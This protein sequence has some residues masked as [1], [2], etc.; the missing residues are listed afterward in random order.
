MIRR[1]P[2]STRTD[3][4]FPYTTLFRSH[5][6][7]GLSTHA[8]GDVAGKLLSDGI[9]ADGIGYRRLIF[10]NDE[11]AWIR[12][13]LVILHARRPRKSVIDEQEAALSIGHRQAKGQQRKQR[14]YIRKDAAAIAAASL[15]LP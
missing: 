1:P 11:I 4:L 5:R 13:L 3:T 6:L 15:L 14:H 12:R 10:P 9:T 2:R 7:I 8:D